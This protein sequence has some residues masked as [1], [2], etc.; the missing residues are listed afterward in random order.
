MNCIKVK[1]NNLL[2]S[3]YSSVSPYFRFKETPYVNFFTDPELSSSL[4][5]FSWYKGMAS[6]TLNWSFLCCSYK[7][8]SHERRWSN[9]DDFIGYTREN[10][11]HLGRCVWRIFLFIYASLYYMHLSFV[12]WCDKRWIFKEHFILVLPTFLAPNLN[13]VNMSSIVR[14]FD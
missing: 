9:H 5:I 4:Y 3:I 1:R 8:T 10:R 13:C 2:N 6:K 14:Q 12:R 7:E 11:S